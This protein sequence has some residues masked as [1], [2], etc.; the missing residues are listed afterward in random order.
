MWIATEPKAQVSIVQCVTTRTGF[1]ADKKGY[2]RRD[3]LKV[4][5]LTSGLAAAG[6]AKDVPEKLIPYV[7][8][9]DEVIEEGR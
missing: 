4:V 5:G 9:P 6:C 3:F 2:N 1:M 8:Q 7:I